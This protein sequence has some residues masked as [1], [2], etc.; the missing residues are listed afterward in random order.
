MHVAV[1]LVLAVALLAPACSAAA[2]PDLALTRGLAYLA[3]QSVGGVSEY[4][5]EAVIGAGQDPGL[6][7]T[8]QLNLMDRL[9]VPTVGTLGNDPIREIHAVAQSGYN[10]YDFKGRDLVS[11]LK[12]A[13]NRSNQGVGQATFTLLGLHAAGVPAT[14]ATYQDALSLLQTGQS[15]DGGWACIGL[16]TADCTGFALTGLRAA[17]GFQPGM[18]ERAKIWLDGARQ[19]NGGYGNGGFVGG[20]PFNI[21]GIASPTPTLTDSNTQSTIWAVHGYRALGQSVPAEMWTYLRSRQMPDGGFAWKDGDSVSN[22]WASTEV[23]AGWTRSFHELPTYADTHVVTPANVEAGVPASFAL[24]DSGLSAAWRILPAPATMTGNP[25]LLTFPI[26][27]PALLHVEATAPGVHHREKLTVQ[28][29]NSGPAFLDLPQNLVADRVTPLNLEFHAVDA[30]DGEVEVEWRFLNATGHGAVN[31]QASQLGTFPLELRSMDRQGA[32]TI[33][34]I[35]VEVRNLAPQLDVLE[36]PAH[37]TAGVPFPFAATAHDPDGPSPR[38]QW[39]FGEILVA[40]PNGTLALPA[41][42]HSV[43]VVLTDSDGANATFQRSLSI[44]APLPPVL[45]VPQMDAAAQEV[46]SEPPTASVPEPESTSALPAALDESTGIEASIGNA[47]AVPGLE[48]GMLA[49]A[50]AAIALRRR[51]A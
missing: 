5:A 40:A 9:V 26:P 25:A 39:Q 50:L 3:A 42:M 33:A 23:I 7:P 48:A 28:V 6:W 32:T 20:D 1:I 24:E 44:Q 10:P 38:I 37:A 22:R 41:G 35:L 4:M 49:L 17:G 29:G 36:L 2:D 15:P 46:D 16:A 14:D 12:A 11:D 19:S 18:Q 27:G 13:W 30:A 31:I 21:L 51:Q 43:Q 8:P 34:T 45:D 47:R